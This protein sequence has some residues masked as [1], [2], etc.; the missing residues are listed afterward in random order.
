MKKTLLLLISLFT[1]ATPTLHGSSPSWP[2]ALSA[3]LLIPL[4]T[5]NAELTEAISDGLDFDHAREIAFSLALP[6]SSKKTLAADDGASPPVEMSYQLRWGYKGAGDATK[7][8]DGINGQFNIQF[9]YD[10]LTFQL[11]KSRSLRQTIRHLIAPVVTVTA[12]Q[13]FYFKL[14]QLAWSVS[15]QKNPDIASVRTALETLIARLK[16]TPGGNEC[17]LYSMPILNAP[18]RLGLES[19]LIQA[20]EQCTAQFIILSQKGGALASLITNTTGA[21]RTAYLN[22]LLAQIDYYQGTPTVLHLPHGGSVYIP[23]W[24][25][26]SGDPA[27]PFTPMTITLMIPATAHLPHATEWTV[28]LDAEQ[29]FLVRGIMLIL[30]NRK[31]P[32]PR[33]QFTEELST[34]CARLSITPTADGKD[35]SYVRSL[36]GLICYYHQTVVRYSFEKPLNKVLDNQELLMQLC[37]VGYHAYTMDAAHPQDRADFVTRHSADALRCY[38]GTLALRSGCAAKTR[39]GYLHHNGVEIKWDLF[40]KTLLGPI[41]GADVEN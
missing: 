2:L 7:P 39:I 31:Q 22:A 35:P 19:Y 8:F 38:Q 10:G 29:A 32:L 13:E 3:P 14:A 18:Q 25:K 5:G 4:L 30:H 26:G 28:T 12:C 20:P 17:S 9:S 23:F 11:C 15:Q 6:T 1:I 36:L 34:L 21:Q 41:P 40:I 33:Y 27:E 16:L 24:E 37:R